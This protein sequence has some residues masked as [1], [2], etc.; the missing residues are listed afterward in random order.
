MAS[1]E[2]TAQQY[3]LTLVERIAV[4]WEGDEIEIPAADF[5]R[6]LRR[7]VHS[8]PAGTTKTALLGHLSIWENDAWKRFVDRLNEIFFFIDS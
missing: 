8:L 5:G 7:V 1:E 6:V 2:S 4:Q 3:L